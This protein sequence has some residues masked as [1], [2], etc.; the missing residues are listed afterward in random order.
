MGN[1]RTP[2]R[3]GGGHSFAK[4][5]RDFSYTMPKKAMRLATRMALLSKFLD[6]QAVVIDGFAVAEPKTKP[7]AD[8]FKAIGLY[9]HGCTLALAGHDANI[10]KSARNLESV[11]VS[12]A[13]ELNAYTVLRQRHLVITRDALDGLLG[14]NQKAEAAA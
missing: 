9:G 6:D 11:L 13:A 12:P 10:W 2:I 5:P 8:L 1:K 7:V 14:R 3:R 4:V